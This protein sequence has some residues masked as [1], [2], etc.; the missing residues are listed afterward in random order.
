M[1]RTRRGGS[2]EEE[3]D[4][5]EQRAHQAL[6][7]LRP[8]PELD[9][10]LDLAD[11]LKLDDLRATQTLVG[12][13]LRA[14]HQLQELDAALEL[15]ADLELDDGKLHAHNEL[16]DTEEEES[17]RSKPSRPVLSRNDDMSVRI[18]KSKEAIVKCSA[19]VLLISEKTLA[20]ELM[21]DS[22]TRPEPREASHDDFDSDEEVEVKESGQERVVQ[23][24]APSFSRAL[25]QH[26]ALDALS[27]DGSFVT[28]QRGSNSSISMLELA[29]SSETINIS[30]NA[31]L[32]D[33]TPT[34]KLTIPTL[35]SS[36][37][38]CSC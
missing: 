9:A 25:Q 37:H 1:A 38:A 19:F 2:G 30:F 27:S 4:G 8:A 17:D 36:R 26:P 14:H 21:K 23:E 6:S 3:L 35:H 5:D 31:L 10:D 34:K 33:K 24:E 11:G 13:E 20:S 22:P 12:D 18:Y 16:Q 28:R 29:E 32:G 15:L 7:D